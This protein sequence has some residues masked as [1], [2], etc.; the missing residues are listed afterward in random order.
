MHVFADLNFITLGNF[1]NA[2]DNDRYVFSYFRP[3]PN[4]MCCDNN[5]AR[6]PSQTNQNESGR[7]SSSAVNR[8]L[9]ISRY[10]DSIAVCIQQF[11]NAVTRFVD[12]LHDE[13]ERL[14]G[15]TYSHLMLS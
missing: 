3:L 2:E 13:D 14:G 7:L 4:T 11:L 6:Q 12:V 15:I 1:L 9:F 10:C 5:F 8:V